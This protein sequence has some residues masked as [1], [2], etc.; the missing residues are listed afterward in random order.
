VKEIPLTKGYTALVDDEDYE[1]VSTLSWNAI[2]QEHTVYA[3]S[4]QNGKT[5]YLH[6]FILGIT[7][8]KIKIDHEDHNGLNCQRYNMRV[9]TQTQNQ[10][11]R[12]KT[13]RPASSQYKGV[14]RHRKKWRVR[15]EVDD[16][17]INLGSFTV[18][19]DAARRYDRAAR[20]HFGEFA[21]TNF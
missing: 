13:T 6:R 16:D 1:R 11:N 12:R 18:E 15:I 10:G 3:A 19:E 14:S 17:N 21:L 2:P 7:D 5:I 9:C 8:C 20:E 4:W